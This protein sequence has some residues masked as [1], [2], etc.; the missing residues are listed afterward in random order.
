[1][2][3]QLHEGTNRFLRTLFDE[4]F[5]DQAE[6]SAGF[7]YPVRTQYAT[8]HMHVRVNSNSVCR[9]DGRG[10][11]IQTLMENLQRDRHVYER[12]ESS[13]KY[14]VTENI[15][16]SLLAAASEH[17]EL[18]GGRVVRES[19]PLMYELGMAAM[20]TIKDDDDEVAR[21]PGRS[22]RAQDGPYPPLSPGREYEYII[23]LQPA[24]ES[25]FLK[26]L[27]HKRAA[28]AET[29]GM[30]PTYLY[31]FHVSVTGFF[32]STPDK[33]GRLVEMMTHLLGDSLAHV[34]VDPV[35]VTHFL[36]TA[37]GYVLIDVRSAVIRDLAKKLSEQAAAEL[38]LK[39]RPKEVNHIS[40]A[41]ERLDH[42]ERGE[43]QELYD[44]DVA[45]CR[46][47]ATFDLVLSRLVRRSSFAKLAQDGSHKFAEFAR[48][49]VVAGPA[50]TRAPVHVLAS[51]GREGVNVPPS[52]PER[53]SP[54][55]AAS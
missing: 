20:P 24:R 34:D 29:F 38:G 2:L 5:L 30:D 23:N 46:E 39:I 26:M 36:G 49:P 8:M 52:S 47:G 31:P 44:S 55:D 11:D 41:S 25:P 45:S 16:V 3:N 42:E 28:C 54:L 50:L 19:M 53:S 10:M 48:L 1:M 51:D 43:I 27:Y 18:Y 17:H 40:V 4:T 37:D 14:S 33:V 6:V 13:F 35:A 12:D 15:K 9:N 22:G 32:K 21:A 7:H